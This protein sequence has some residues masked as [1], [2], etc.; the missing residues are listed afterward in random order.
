MKP[1][2]CDPPNTHQPHSLTEEQK[3]H[4][5]RLFNMT[6]RVPCSPRPHDDSGSASAVAQ[7]RSFAS[8]SLMCWRLTPSVCV[9]VCLSVKNLK[10]P[11]TDQKSTKGSLRPFDRRLQK[12]LHP[13]G[14]C[15]TVAFRP[16]FFLNV[17][18]SQPRVKC[19]FHQGYEGAAAAPVPLM[20]AKSRRAHL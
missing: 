19:T 3:T 7:Q 18:L 12:L 14:T 2:G 13:L 9:F 8:C 20:N 10:L 5:C 1:A 16:F 15:F 4:I 11:Q 6:S 17:L